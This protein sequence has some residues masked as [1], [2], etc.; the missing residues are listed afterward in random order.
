MK[1]L[2]I[3]CL[4][5]LAA[6]L[7]VACGTDNQ[8]GSYVASLKSEYSI[9]EDTII[10]K[11][12]VVTNRVGYR[13]ILNGELKPKKWSVKQWRLNEWGSAVIVFQENGLLIGDTHYKRI[14]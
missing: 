13:R 1:K 7:F 11:D 3:G 8:N 5:S 12:N 10:I 6:T 9:A 4:A 2:L 14:D